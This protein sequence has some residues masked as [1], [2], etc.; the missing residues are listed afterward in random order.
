MAAGCGHGLYV[1]PGL[2][3]PSPA[4]PTETALRLV[5]IGDTGSAEIAAAAGWPLGARLAQELEA[6]LQTT[7]VFLGD[8]VY[9]AGVPATEGS[10]EA[11]TAARILDVQLAATATADDVLFVPGNHD[12]NDSQLGGLDRIRAQGRLIDKLAGVKHPAR[13]LP[14]DG[15][16]GPATVDIEQIVR[17]VVI[18]TEWLLID[19]DPAHKPIGAD[20]G[21]SYG[22]PQAPA[23]FDGGLTR[24]SFYQTL[25]GELRSDAPVVLLAHHPLRSRGPHGGY[26]GAGPLPIVVPFIRRLLRRRQDFGSRMYDEMRSTIDEAVRAA[27]APLV[28]VAGGH[29]HNLQVFDSPSIIYYLVSGAGSKTSGSGRSSTTMFKAGVHGYMRLDFLAAGRVLLAVVDTATPGDTLSIQLH[30]RS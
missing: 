23:S 7:V 5:L 26:L 17:L 10:P 30:P 2:S 9:P 24:K 1:R 18:D 8:N 6:D 15:C 13:L 12:W 28:V 22:S 16:P 3:N 20:T 27:G 14:A 29:E 11:D 25:A 19:D 4:G 21:C